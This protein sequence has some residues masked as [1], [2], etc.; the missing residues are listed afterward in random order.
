KSIYDAL[1]AAK[2]EQIKAQIDVLVQ[3]LNANTAKSTI[4]TTYDSPEDKVL[5]QLVSFYLMNGGQK[6]DLGYVSSTGLDYFNKK[7]AL[8][9]NLQ[10]QPDFTSSMPALQQMSFSSNNQG[11]PLILSTKDVV[12]YS[13]EVL[14]HM[15]GNSYDNVSASK[16]S[17]LAYNNFLKGA[18]Q[19]SSE[20]SIESKNL[21]SPD[22][23]AAALNRALPLISASVLYD[24]AGG[25]VT[26][27]TRNATPMSKAAENILKGDEELQQQNDK[28][29][30]TEPKGYI[31][32]NAAPLGNQTKGKTDEK[33]PK[34]DI[35]KEIEDLLGN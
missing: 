31:Q 21:A 17:F 13:S 29:I 14:A 27:T 18:F 22:V 15:L 12:E 24:Q 11:L 34:R 5:L 25:K 1:L 20:F 10:P 33:T 19:Q 26:V 9:S 30:Q 28:V 35:N 8:Q 4:P 6:A 16:G 23:F 2:P 32:N 3:A 7:S